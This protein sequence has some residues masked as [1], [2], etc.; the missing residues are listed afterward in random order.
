M[1]AISAAPRPSGD[2]ARL[3]KWFGYLR[4]QEAYLREISSQLDRGHT[5][6]AQRLF[7]RFIHS[8]NLANNS[9]LAF[10]FDYCTFKFSRFG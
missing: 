9:T 2:V 8:G 6:K 4:Q 10:G 1:R 7:T 3:Q 5:I